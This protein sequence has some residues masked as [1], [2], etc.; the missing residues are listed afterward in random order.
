M[1]ESNVFGDELDKYIE[2]NEQTI[3]KHCGQTM[4][5]TETMCNY[6]GKSIEEPIEQMGEEKDKW[7]TFLLIM[8]TGIF[9]GHKFYEGK[10]VQGCLYVSLTISVV[11]VIVTLL[12]CV[13]DLCVVL[14][15]KG[16]YYV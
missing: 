14:T 15:K 7:I 3:C 10:H 6:C 8:F 12:L 5:A 2:D 11:G 16:K 1:G 9:G 4:L 13:I